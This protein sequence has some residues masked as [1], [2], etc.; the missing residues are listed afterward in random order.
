MPEIKMKWIDYLRDR[1]RKFKELNPES[2]CSKFDIGVNT[3]LNY[4]GNTHVIDITTAFRTTRVVTKFSLSYSMYNV[5]RVSSCIV[6]STCSAIWKDEK[7]SIKN[8]FDPYSVHHDNVY[9]ALVYVFEHTV[10]DT[11]KYI[12]STVMSLGNAQD[13]ADIEQEY[14]PIT[15]VVEEITPEFIQSL[16]PQWICEIDMSVA[17]LLAKKTKE[18]EELGKREHLKFCNLSNKYDQDTNDLRREIKRLKEEKASKDVQIMELMQKNS[19]LLATKDMEPA[20]DSRS[21]VK[22]L[23][24]DLD[25]TTNVVREVN[26][27]LNISRAI[28]KGLCEKLEEQDKEI[29]ENKEYL[30]DLAHHVATLQA[31]LGFR[32]EGYVP[33]DG[34]VPP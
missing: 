33:P 28:T 11:S 27:A 18:I 19:E 30:A 23:T 8:A 9:N 26:E 10:K 1:F 3:D 6:Y 34:D 31:R 12:Q 32:E 24:E 7:R 14:P 20:S 16:E 22:K 2:L 21:I 4:K 15:N 13:K 17:N 5:K 29:L 25:A